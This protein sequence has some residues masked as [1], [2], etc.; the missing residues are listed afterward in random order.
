MNLDG[1]QM[2]VLWRN[3]DEIGHDVPGDW[4]GKQKCNTKDQ[5]DD[6]FSVSLLNTDNGTLPTLHQRGDDHALA[7]ENHR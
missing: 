7:R 5:E 3:F 6:R 1:E 2:F 4:F